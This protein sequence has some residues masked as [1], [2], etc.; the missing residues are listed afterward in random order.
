MKKFVTAGS[1][2]L[3]MAALVI[4]AEQA[5]TAGKTKAAAAPEHKALNASELTWVDA[6]PSL[7]PGA[8]MAVLNGD[9]GKAGEF[10]VR[11]QSPAGYAI[12][13]HSHPTTERVTVVSGTFKVGMGSTVNESSMQELGPGG[14]VVLPAGMAHYAKCDSESIVQIDSDGPFKIKYVNPSDDPRSKK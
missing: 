3:G 7:P 5:G 1:V 4:A 12:P 13:P 14:Y 9:P 8:K 2:I 11:L 10:T 6:P